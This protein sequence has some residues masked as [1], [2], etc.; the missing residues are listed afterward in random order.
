[1]SAILVLALLQSGSLPADADPL[2]PARQGKLQCTLPDP[3]KKSCMA[4][5]RYVPDGER[6]YLNITR[7]LISGAPDVILEFRFPTVIEGG[8]ACGIMAR[9]E[10]DEAILTVDGVPASEELRKQVVGSMLPQLEPDFGKRACTRIRDERALL[11]QYLEIDGEPRPQHRMRVSW[12]D[13]TEGYRL[14]IGSE[15]D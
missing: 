8:A 14:R 13:A 3:V 4:I 7:S 1:M 5:S 15:P 10:L 2:A 12:V 9:S 11:F 6:R